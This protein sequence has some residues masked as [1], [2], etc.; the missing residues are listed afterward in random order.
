MS[1]DGLCSSYDYAGPALHKEY[2][3]VFLWYLYNGVTLTKD[4][5]ARRNW[6][7]STKCCFCNLSEN[8]EHLLLNCTLSKFI[9]R[10]IYISFNIQPPVD[11]HHMFDDWL[12]GTE[13]K[14][15]KLIWSEIP[16]LCWAIWLCRNDVVFVK[17]TIQS[18]L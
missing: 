9:W 17:T 3:E 5:L 13:Y 2:L 7:G 14:L 8:I 10:I 1:L 12:R 11:F 16:S 4:N 15:K 6:N 18:F